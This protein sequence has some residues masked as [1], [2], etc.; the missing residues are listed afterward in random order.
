MLHAELV[1]LL[2]LCFVQWLPLLY[3]CLVREQALRLT[4]SQALA[5]VEE[6]YNWYL[7]ILEVLIQERKMMT[8]LLPIWILERHLLT[9]ELVVQRI[10][11]VR[12]TLLF[13]L[14]MFLSALALL[15]VLLDQAILEELVR[16]RAL[17]IVDLDLLINI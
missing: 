3:A 16:R 15:A 12:I 2:Y 5:K 7:L 1:I 13:L 9:E 17:G 4:L 14:S 11:R 8:D 10:R 6:S